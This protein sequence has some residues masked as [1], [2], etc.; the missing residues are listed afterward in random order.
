[1][2]RKNII[3]TELEK[4]TINNFEKKGWSAQ[5]LEPIVNYQ[6]NNISRDLNE[7]NREKKVIK[8]DGRPV[9]F[10]ANVNNES[11]VYF[12]NM[13]DYLS[14]LKEEKEI[15]LK[16]EENTSE[17]QTFISD[18]ENTFSQLIG[19]D[20]SM[21][22]QVQ[23]AVASVMYPPK[24]LDTLLIGESGVG[25]STFAEI[26]YQF[27]KKTKKVDKDAPFVIFNCADYSSNSQLLLSHLFGYI[28]GAFTGADSE[29]KGIIDA[30]DNGI[31]FLDEVHRLPPEGQ[32]ML[33][34]LMDRG[35]FRRLGESSSTRTANVLIIMATT[36]NPKQAML[37]TFLRR[38]PNIIEIPSLKNRSLEERME[39]IVR[40]F[41]NQSVQLGKEIHVSY[42]VIKFLLIYECQQNIGQLFNDIKLI[43][44]SS[45]VEM[46]TKNQDIVY[47][48]LSQLPKQ[49]VE[50]FDLLDTNR[51]SMLQKI[52]S[53]YKEFIFYPEGEMNG[54]LNQHLFEHKYE[55]NFYQKIEKIS[56]DYFKE[57]LELVEVQ[58]LLDEEVINYFKQNDYLKYHGNKVNENPLYKIVSKERYESLSHLIFKLLKSHSIEFEEAGV[59]GLILH[60]NSLIERITDNQSLRK[61]KS[62]M[63]VDNNSIFY[64]MSLELIT[65]IESLWH[66]NI[67]SYEVSF[68]SIFFESLAAE[69]EKNKIGILTITHGDSSRE[70]SKVVNSL[71]KV[72][73]AHYLCMPIDESPNVILEEAIKKVE[74]IDEGKG[75]LLLVDMG[76]LTTFGDIINKE[77]GIEVRTVNM[78]STLT[79]LEATRLSLMTSSTLDTIVKNLGEVVDYTPKIYQD[80]YQDFRKNEKILAMVENILTFVNP[81]KVIKSLTHVFEDILEKQNINYSDSLYIKFLFHTSCMI[82]RVIKNEPYSY[83]NFDEKLS[84]YLDLYSLMEESFESINNE[85][86]IL[87]P[88]SELA[89]VVEIFIYNNETI[90][91]KALKEI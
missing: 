37:N 27:A 87:I 78:V 28:E 83:K 45:F 52:M 34:S 68:V 53:S 41:I 80:S 77:T 50:Y 38:V 48:K 65:Q 47:V 7:L 30:A 4:L 82:E 39:L 59:I 70:L 31:L 17:D 9:H 40:C 5:E 29:K 42:E 90:F 76:S 72:E 63:L 33:F 49:Y 22:S 44:A 24:G 43:C 60:L 36:E 51:E 15:E 26:M 14:F 12:K 18:I 10:L 62:E 55:K 67:P 1:M 73:Q 35:E 57:G 85:W 91:E 89:Y 6:R 2:C 88:K 64:E 75:V 74:E 11:D 81:N 21:K 20:K 79:L 54:K 86:G 71:L 69:K 46:L 13:E 8:I 25:K 16:K 32:E 19:F 56:K 23:R 58:Q 84:N 66:F 61:P 3:F